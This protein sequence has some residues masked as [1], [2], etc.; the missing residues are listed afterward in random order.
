MEMNDVLLAGAIDDLNKKHDEQVGNLAKLAEE[1]AAMITLSEKTMLDK[2]SDVESKLGDIYSD[3]SA[4]SSRF[5]ETTFEV[6][7]I[8]NE[9]ASLRDAVAAMSISKIEK[10]EEEEEEAAEEVVLEINPSAPSEDEATN[11]VNY[12]DWI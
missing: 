3:M 6:T 4:H 7:V 1:T 12:N 9:M 8:K 10:L 11:N 5:E 2:L